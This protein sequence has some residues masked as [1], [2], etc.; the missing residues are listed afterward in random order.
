MSKYILSILGIVVVGVFIDIVIPTGKINQFIKSV[1]GIFVVLV[2]AN[3]II[4]LFKKV[5]NYQFN[6]NNYE[7]NQNLL[8]YISKMKVE[9]MEGDIEKRISTEGL[10]NVKV[11]I[12]FSQELDNLQINSCNVDLRNMTSSSNKVHSNRYEIVINAVKEVANL[13][14]EVIIFYEWKRKQI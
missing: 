3:P 4:S 11:K 6:Y 7:V 12:N 9:A 5:S 2:I 1:Y 13:D 14:K 10:N 8:N